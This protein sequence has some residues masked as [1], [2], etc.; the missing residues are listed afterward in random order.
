[1]ALSCSC[2]FSPL[3]WVGD[4]SESLVLLWQC[5]FAVNAGTLQAWSPRQ[6]GGG[7]FPVLACSY[8]GGINC[9]SFN[10]S[11]SLLPFLKVSKGILTPQRNL[12]LQ[13]RNW[14]CGTVNCLLPSSLSKCRST[15]EHAWYKP[16]SGGAVPSGGKAPVK[17]WLLYTESI[18]TSNFIILF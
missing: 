1:M 8:K 2:S 15:E 3:Y 5:L 18:Q 16:N 7:I 13:G 4:T 14:G 17:G 6:R 12:S 10:L 9:K 11:Q